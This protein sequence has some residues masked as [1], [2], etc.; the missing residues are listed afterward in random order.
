[1]AEVPVLPS[2]VAV[3]VA[4]PAATPVTSPLPFTV[5]NAVALLDQVTTR[6]GRA[7]PFASFGVAVS[8][9]VLPA[10]R[11]ADAGVTVTEATGTTGT[12][13]VITEVPAL[14][15]LVAVIV[16]GPA[17]TPVTSPLPFT[18]ANAVASLDQV[19]TR[20]WR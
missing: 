11:L 8:W 5:A 15:S 4:G 17:A 12:T 20:P 3:I 6:P 10:S 7:V 13:T 2:L 14:P 9:T 19:T 16:A 18:V 1:M